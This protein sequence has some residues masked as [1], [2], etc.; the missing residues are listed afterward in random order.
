MQ[1]KIC[2]NKKT[3]YLVSIGL[4]IVISALSLNMLTRQKTST[5]SRAAEVL[6]VPTPTPSPVACNIKGA[7]IVKDITGLLWSWA[8]L[9]TG[10]LCSSEKILTTDPNYSSY[11]AKA[12]VYPDNPVA[13]TY[14]FMEQYISKGGTCTRYGIDIDIELNKDAGG[15]YA[16]FN[17]TL[18]Q[19]GLTRIPAVLVATDKKPKLE[20]GTVISDFFNTKCSVSGA[21]PTC[22]QGRKMVVG[23]QK[24][25]VAYTNCSSTVDSKKGC[26]STY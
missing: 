13:G 8:S 7:V 24:W 18:N 17:P 14:R 10:T 16:P 1:Q 4:I 5:N 23:T 26:C 11:L 21:L 9:K 22:Q 2:F 20:N 25:S 6:E 19:A 3:G 12:I 15:L